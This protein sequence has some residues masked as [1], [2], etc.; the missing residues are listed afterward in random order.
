MLTVRLDAGTGLFDDA[1]L[2]ALQEAH[3]VLSVSGHA[4]TYAGVPTLAL[5]LRTRERGEAAP[6]RR[7]T[8][9]GR[10]PPPADAAPPEDR[11][12]FEALRQWRNE[13]ARLDGRPAYVLFLVTPALDGPAPA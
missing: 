6:T 8:G 10:P 4:F 9:G 1:S 7:W 12:T 11:P 3:E 5:L 13:R 2:A